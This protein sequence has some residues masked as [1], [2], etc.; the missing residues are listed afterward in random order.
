MLSAVFSVSLHA[1]RRTVTVEFSTEA[2]ELSQ[3]DTQ[4]TI[5]FSILAVEAPHIPTPPHI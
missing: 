2:V 4:D 3:T 1:V 5:E